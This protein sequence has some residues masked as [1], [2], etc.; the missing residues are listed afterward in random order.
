MT[1]INAEYSDQFRFGGAVL[2]Q[3]L[4]I[5]KPPRYIGRLGQAANI[6]AI[7][8]TFVPLTLSYQRGV[9]TQVSSQN[10]ALDIDTYRERVLMPQIVRLNNLID[11]DVC[12]LAQGL[13]QSVGTPAVTP[14]TLPTYLAA[15]TKL[16]NL[17]AP[18]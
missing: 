11:Q 10:L 3:T 17:A 1:R 4:S 7:T 18:M 15:K 16:D 9:D 5:R 8:E 14:T 6:E 12:N 2:G 13:A